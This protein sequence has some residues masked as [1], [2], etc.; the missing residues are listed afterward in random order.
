M[1]V[2]GPDTLSAVKKSL[3]NHN[4]KPLHHPVALGDPGIL[5]HHLGMDTGS[6]RR[7]S[8]APCEHKYCLVTHGGDNLQR[9]RKVSK[10]NQLQ[11]FLPF[12]TWDIMVRQLETCEHVLCRSL[13]CIILSNAM[14]IPNVF[15][16]FA[17][18]TNHEPIFKYIDYYK[19]LGVDADAMPYYEDVV[20]AK[21]YLAGTQHVKLL[22]TQRTVKE[23]MESFPYYL[24]KRR[25][26]TVVS[27][28]L[29]L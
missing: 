18:N 27:S 10:E 12:T 28:S 11:Y 3:K 9:T 19:S 6:C 14:E 4:H 8:L 24:F 5:L 16:Q 20:L 26:V 23:L 21:D 29:R 1:A 13:H 25:D 7:D 22:H 15:F 17:N 2:R